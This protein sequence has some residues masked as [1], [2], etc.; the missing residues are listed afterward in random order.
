MRWWIVLPSV[1]AATYLLMY[2]TL[3]LRVWKR[4]GKGP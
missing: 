3:L 4:G 2:L 1:L